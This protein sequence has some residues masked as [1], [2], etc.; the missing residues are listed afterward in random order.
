[1][2]QADLARSTSLLHYTQIRMPYAGT[3]VERNVD[4]GDFV[5]PAN[6]A[7]AKPLFAVARSDIVRIFVDV[8]EMEAAQIEVGAKGTVHVQALPDRTN[9]GHGDADKLGL[10]CKPH[11]TNGT[12]Y[13]Q[14]PRSA[15]VPACMPVRKSF[16]EQRPD[17]LALPLAAVVNIDQKAYCCCVENGRIVRSPLLSACGQP[18]TWK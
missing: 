12:G 14:P 9:R 6:I 5:Q 16:S 4:R 8:P 18:R 7:T 2:P 15:R 17:V 1:M 3:V 11:A 13:S 10:R